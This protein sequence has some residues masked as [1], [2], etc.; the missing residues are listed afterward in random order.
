MTIDLTQLQDW[1]P[2]VVTLLVAIG[3]L[4]R[5]L[6]AVRK[7]IN[8]E[9]THNHGT[10]VKDD[11]HGIA[12]AVGKLQRDFDDLTTRFDAHLREYPRK[13]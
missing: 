13:P 11:V 3:W 2:A 7:V 4:S 12:V 1:L 8:K 5:R 10:S 9:L 6:E